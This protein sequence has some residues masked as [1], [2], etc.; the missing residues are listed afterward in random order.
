MMKDSSSPSSVSSSKIRFPPAP[1]SF[2]SIARA[3]KSLA[4]SAFA[5]KKTP[6]PAHSPSALITTGQSTFESAAF[7][8]R[9]D[10][11]VPYIF[12]V[13]ILCRVKNSFEKNL[14]SFQ[15]RSLL[16]RPHNPPISLSKRVRQ[17][18]HKREFWPN[19]GQVR[20][21]FFCQRNHRSHI[22][23]INSHAFRFCSNAAVPRSA[24]DFF[25]QRALL[26]FPNQRVLAPASAN[27]QNL[28]SSL[29]PL[30]RF[31]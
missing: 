18:I 10:L 17:S 26:E 9:A 20:L 24:P 2:L 11:Q 30:R 28:H 12:A 5:A 29:T 1:N 8:A 4:S 31:R 21:N 7:A 25:H 14:A 16:R 19:N 22:T 15:L 23:R 6:F 3:I 13:G 27:H